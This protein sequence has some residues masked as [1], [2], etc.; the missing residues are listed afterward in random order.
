MT[1]QPAICIECR[2]K[3]VY[4]HFARCFACMQIRWHAATEKG[5]ATRARHKRARQ[6]HRREAHHADR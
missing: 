5:V 1:P 6:R 4:A 3:P 2:Q